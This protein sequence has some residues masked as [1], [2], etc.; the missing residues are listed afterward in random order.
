MENEMV[1]RC[2]TAI[3]VGLYYTFLVYIYLLCNCALPLFLRFLLLHSF[4]S[5]DDLPENFQRTRLHIGNNLLFQEIVAID[6]QTTQNTIKFTC[7]QHITIKQY[8]RKKKTDKPRI[9]K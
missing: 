1:I 8:Q 2:R 4:S 6:G 9:Q 7:M 3:K 5:H